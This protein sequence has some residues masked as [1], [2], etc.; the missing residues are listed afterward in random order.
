M[1]SEEMHQLL[2]NWYVS[3]NAP[4]INFRESFPS[5]LDSADD[6]RVIYE[7]CFEP[8]TLD[9]ARIEVWLTDE[10]NIALGFETRQRIAEKLGVANWRMGFAAGHEPRAISGESVIALL[11]AVS[12]GNILLRTRTIFGVLGGIRATMSEEDRLNL[13]SAGCDYVDW[14]DSTAATLLPSRFFSTLVPFQPWK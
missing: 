5:A 10:G 14:I 8:P 9:K 12:D 11:N 13:M 3:K 6:Y 7:A 1:P 4:H 2:S